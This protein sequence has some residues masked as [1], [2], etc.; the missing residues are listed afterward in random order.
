MVSKYKIMCYHTMAVLLEP[1]DNKI[2]HKCI[3]IAIK[4]F[5]IFVIMLALCLEL[6]KTYYAQDYVAI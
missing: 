2:F 4:L 6:S 1:I 3:N 5:Y